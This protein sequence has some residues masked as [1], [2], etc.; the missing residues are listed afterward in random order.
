VEALRNH[1]KLLEERQGR[2]RRLI[3]TL[4]RTVAQYQGGDMLTEEEMY[5]GFA[6]EKIESIRKEARELHGAARVEESERRV[7][8]MSREAWAA[9]GREGEGVNRDLAA[10]MGTGRDA[11]DAAVQAVVSRHLAWIERFW[12]PTAEAY[13]G[14]GNHYVDH[15]EFRAYYERYAPGLAD[16]LRRAIE[17]YCDRWPAG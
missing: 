12:T 3:E 17:S 7:R 2:L 8:G 16:F 9:V 10:L 6:P 13:R 5:R 11:G 15:P 14:L 4:D 1:R